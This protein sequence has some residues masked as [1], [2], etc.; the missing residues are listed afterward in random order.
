[1]TDLLEEYRP[2]L[3]ADVVT[4]K[5]DVREAAARLPE[6]DRIARHN[7]VD[8]THTESHSHATEHDMAKEAIP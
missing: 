7:R 5:I 4:G 2:R 1:M 3:I 6:V 8:E